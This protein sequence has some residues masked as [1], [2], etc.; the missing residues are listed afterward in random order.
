MRI[1]LQKERLHLF[2][3]SSKSTGRFKRKSLDASAELRWGT[4]HLYSASLLHLHFL[5]NQNPST[6]YSVP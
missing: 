6:H 5:S 3:E 4:F 1:A 2:D